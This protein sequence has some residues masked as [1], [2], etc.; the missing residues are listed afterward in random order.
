[1]LMPGVTFQLHY[2]RQCSHFKFLLTAG[3][4]VKILPFIIVAL[5]FGCTSAD[6]SLGGD[7]HLTSPD[8]GHSYIRRGDANEGM[9]VVDQQVVDVEQDGSYIAVLRKVARSSTCIRPAKG[10]TILTLYTDED[11]YWLIDTNAQIEMGPLSSDQYSEAL[12]KAHKPYIRL[13]VPAWFHPNVDA[14]RRWM[15]GCARN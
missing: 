7:Y 9:I 8:T 6:R 12:K 14:Y 11:Q 2:L 10:P 5:S 3:K 1:M 13:T 15:S 4:Q